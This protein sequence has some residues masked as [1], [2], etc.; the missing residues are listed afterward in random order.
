MAILLSTLGM[1]FSCEN[2]VA[3]IKELQIDTIYP[4]QSV[5]DVEIQYSELGRVVLQLNAPILNQYDGKEPYEEM[6]EGVHVR[7]FDSLM[8]VTSELTANYAIKMTHSE[9]MEA[10]YD[11]VVTNEKGEKLNTEHLVWDKT[12]GE[13]TSDVFV[14]ITTLDQV[15]MGDGLIS[16]QDFSDYRI[17]KPRGI[18]NIDN[19]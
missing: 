5:K 9:K 11:V 8:N 15:I 16:N 2:S 3:E 10:K 1:F 18:I 19:D 14:K 13:I 17:L 4:N 12:T 7:I 6:P